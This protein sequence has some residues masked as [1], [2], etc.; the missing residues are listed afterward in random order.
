LPKSKREVLTAF[1]TLEIL[2]EGLFSDVSNLR[3][4]PFSPALVTRVIRA[5]Q[6]A[7][8]IDR[9]S[10]G[11]YVLSDDFLR[12]TFKDNRAAADQWMVKAMGEAVRNYRDAATEAIN[13][14]EGIRDG[15]VEGL[16]EL[17]G[18]DCTAEALDLPCGYKALR[19]LLLP[20]MMRLVDLDNPQR[21][22]WIPDLNARYV[23]RNLYTLISAVKAQQALS[24][25][26]TQTGLMIITMLAGPALS[27]AGM[28]GEV[29]E[30]AMSAPG[31]NTLITF[32]TEI[33]EGLRAKWEV[34]FAQ[35]ASLVLGQERLSEA[36]AHRNE[37][38][39]GLASALGQAV[40]QDVIAVPRVGAEIRTARILDEI[41]ALRGQGYKSLD[42][43]YRDAFLRA[44]ID[45]KV[46]E[47]TGNAKAM[48]EFDKRVSATFDKV[49]EDMNFRAAT[50]EPMPASATYTRVLSGEATIALG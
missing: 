28:I 43:K 15:Y 24:S 44:A 45:A 3:K 22:R 5:L 31:A 9:I 50:T 39:N 35:G 32:A 27:E 6:D 21:Y 29:V 48:S 17:L 8:V 38:V 30:S 11:K 18:Q 33:P 12:R 42:P 2:I 19:P 20:R 34:R 13:T 7:K 16:I 37:W 10:H 25:V 49:A 26:S 40:I 1:L 36:V 46:L 23:S 41:E 14:A 4:L 47:A